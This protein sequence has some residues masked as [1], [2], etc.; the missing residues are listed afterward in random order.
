[1]GL[2]NNT[3]ADRRIVICRSYHNRN[4]N[5]MQAF[6]GRAIGNIHTISLN[7]YKQQKTGTDFI[8]LKQRHKHNAK[9]KY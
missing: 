8:N 5:T 6:P 4:M 7:I 2:A 9:I 1:M 3:I